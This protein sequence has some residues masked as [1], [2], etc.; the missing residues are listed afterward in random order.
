MSDLTTEGRRRLPASD[1]ALP[2]DVMDRRRGF[3]GKYPIDT[4]ARA[5]NA[6]ARGSQMY[7]R[8]LLTRGELATIIRKVQRRYPGIEISDELKELAGIRG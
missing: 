1:F 2:P 4:E 7:D 5:R 3:K 8:R 6:L